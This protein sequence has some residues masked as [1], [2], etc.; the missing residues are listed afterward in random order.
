MHRSHISIQKWFEAA[1]WTANHTPGMSATQLQ[2][3]LGLG[4]HETAWHMLHRL[5]RGMVNEFRSKL[6]GHLEADE[7][8]IG[9]PAKGKKGRGVIQDPNKSLVFGAVEVLSYIDKK[10]EP[11]KRS[12]RVRLLVAKSADAESIRP[13][14][15]DNV[16]LGSVIATD[17]WRGY[18][19]DAMKGFKHESSPQKSGKG[20]PVYAPHIH[21]AFG[22]LKTWLRGTYHGVDPKHL[23]SY[24]DEFAFR[25]NRRDTPMAAFQTLLGISLQ[26]N[27]LPLSKLTN[28]V[29]TR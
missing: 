6:N 1:Y 10:G 16:E 9:G 20:P 5:R 28:G 17:G 2:K 22:N 21:R 12:G 23:Q 24:L 19:I 29:S 4:C 25:F 8:F 13:F 26:R 3:H 15:I 14:L 27:P 11:K 7:A 18:S